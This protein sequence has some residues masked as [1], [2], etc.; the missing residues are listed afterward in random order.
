MLV[1][2]LDGSMEEVQAST[3]DELQRILQDRCGRNQTV[4]IVQN[5]SLG[6]EKDEKDDDIF[7]ALIVKE[8][9]L[10]PEECLRIFSAFSLAWGAADLDILGGLLKTYHAVVAGGAVVNAYTSKRINDFDVYINRRNA[11]EFVQ[12]IRSKLGMHP[13]LWGMCTAAP[14]DTSFMRQNRVLC[15]VPFIFRRRGREVIM[16]LIILSD[17]VEVL[18]VVSNFDLTFCESWWDG[19]YAYSNDPDGL[20][21]RQ[22]WLKPAYT[23]RLFEDLNIFTIRRIRKYRARGWTVFLSDDPELNGMSF[24]DVITYYRNED[25]EDEEDGEDEDREVRSRLP[26]TEKVA[27]E[28]SVRLLI[29]ESMNKVMD[30]SSTDNWARVDDWH[31]LAYMIAVTPEHYTYAEICEIFATPSTSADRV[32]HLLA[33]DVITDTHMYLEMWYI[34]KFCELFRVSRMDAKLSAEERLELKK[35][36][37]PLCEK[38]IT[39]LLTDKK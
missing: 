25:D 39:D 19:K 32:M 1:R 18:E 26:H 7:N 16:D 30:R 2:W 36:V 20:R 8:P 24:D 31:V 29:K 37:K 5:S 11:A 17:E 3:I 21:G 6:D 35:A 27:E 4:K 34:P 10:T 13:R 22:G 14:Y 15:R 9:K 33:R 28:L 38:W 23:K 12:A